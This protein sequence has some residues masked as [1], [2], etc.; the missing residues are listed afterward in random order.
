MCEMYLERGGITLQAT[1]II[2]YRLKMLQVPLL[3][4]RFVLSCDL[5]ETSVYSATKEYLEIV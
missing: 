5:F 2:V 1:P 4:L 3:L